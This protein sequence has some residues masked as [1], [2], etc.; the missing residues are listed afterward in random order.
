LQ[1]SAQDVIRTA[2]LSLRMSLARLITS[3][4]AVAWVGRFRLTA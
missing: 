2:C 4:G 1:G 3:S